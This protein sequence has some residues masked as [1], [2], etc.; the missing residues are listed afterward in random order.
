VTIV[1]ATN[2]GCLPG[3][4]LA[5]LLAERVPSIEE[6]TVGHVIAGGGGPSRGS[7][8][9]ALANIDAFNNGGL[10]YQDGDWRSG[11]P[12]RHSSVMLPGASESTEM[13]KL[14]LGEVVTIPRHVQAGYVESVVEASLSARLSTPIS[15]D[16]I[17]TLPEGPTEEVRSAQQ[18]TYLIDVTGVD[19]HAVR[20]L[21]TG[22][23]TYGTTALIAV[24]AARR[25][26]V[27]GAKAGV[28]A[29]A[30]AFN[31][32]DFLDFLASHGLRWTIH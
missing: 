10:T 2:D 29:P 28:L 7:L 27:D 30:Q 23:D 32:V 1:P 25:L 9:S 4:L 17:D 19:G 14:A 11:V 16:I 8:R 20:G 18:F 26:T 21:L 13:A 6:I 24:E 12:A 22:A 15:P 3:D 31:P 5:H